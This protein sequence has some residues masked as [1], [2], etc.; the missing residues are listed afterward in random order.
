[1]SLQRYAG[2]ILAIMF[3]KDNFFC[4]SSKLHNGVQY[5]VAGGVNK[6][7]KTFHVVIIIITGVKLICKYTFSAE[8]L[9]YA[10][11]SMTK[12]QWENK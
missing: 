12:E 6:H 4:L 3:S 5:V 8:V 1:M 9:D 10:S 2:E 7:I 11:F